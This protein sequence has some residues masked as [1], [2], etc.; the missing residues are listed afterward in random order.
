MRVLVTAASKHGATA[1]IAGLIAGALIDAGIDAV[2]E[3]P[4]S[5][6]SIAEY[7]AFVIG[8][9]VYLGH[10]LAPATELIER[11]AAELVG[12]PVW[13]FSSGPVGDPPKPAADAAEVAALS[14]LVKAREHRVFVGRIDRHRLGMAEKLIIAAVHAPEGDFRVPSEITEWAA[15]I[16]RSLQVPV[17]AG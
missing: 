17:F 5:V 1:D 9:A 11:N 15:H 12:K 2:I 16:A 3:R 10:W 14:G 6:T 4:E 13:L 7:D 8:S